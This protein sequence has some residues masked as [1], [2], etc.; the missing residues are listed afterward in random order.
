M[1]T[2]LQACPVCGGVEL[3]IQKSTVA[4]D[5]SGQSKAA[6]PLCGWT[7]LE[8]ETTAFATTEQVWT[9]E[10]VAEVTI[11]IVA[12]HAT[13]PLMQF[14]EFTGILPRMRTITRT[15]TGARRRAIEKHNEQTQT[16]RD[17]V[18]RA[19]FAA[20]LEAA[21]KT[22]AEMREIYAETFNYLEKSDPQNNETSESS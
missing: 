18:F 9:I 21:W 3:E 15:T 19:S 1:T 12:K 7:G 5:G 11:R 13:G 14:W 17:A 2:V 20:F 10:R 6:C 16:S 8:A 22:A 4:V